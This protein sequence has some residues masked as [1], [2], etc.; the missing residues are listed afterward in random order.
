LSK[1]ILFEEAR[2]REFELV[3]TSGKAKTVLTV[4]DSFPQFGGE[5]KREGCDPH[6]S[7]DGAMEKRL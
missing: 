5:T 2:N 1:K 3:L 7:F 6:D 4:F